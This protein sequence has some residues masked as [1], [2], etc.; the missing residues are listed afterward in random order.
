M[1]YSF[2]AIPGFVAALLLLSCNDGTD[3]H[4]QGI[5]PSVAPIPTINYA[6]VKPF[7]H[8]ITYF[9]EGLL[10]YNGQLFES[11]GSP[12]DLPYTRS[13]VGSLDTVT[14]KMNIKVELDRKKYFGEGI[15]ILNNKLYQLTYKNRTCFVYDAQTFKRIGQFSYSNPEGWGLTTNGTEI[16]MSDGTDK[17]T[18]LHPDQ[19]TPVKQL[20][21]TENG[22]P[23]NYLNEL[24]YIGG[25]IYANIWLR[26][27]IVK[28]DPANGKIVGRLDL[29]SL[30]REAKARQAEAG[31]LNGIAWDAVTDKIYVTGKL[32]ANLYQINF[33]H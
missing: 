31:A 21:V 23:R 22:S 29:S 25:F 9:T 11:T 2:K 5:T 20:A 30:A 33:P 17:L 3:K 7:P 1:H 19:F 27:E 24:E 14:G 18:F 26:D 32:W 10:V 16:I 6:V 28:I 4:N 15:V 13:L 12:D 8:D